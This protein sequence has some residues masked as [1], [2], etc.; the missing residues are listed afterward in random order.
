MKLFLSLATAAVFV[1]G[2][3]SAAE[4]T[5][6]IEGVQPGAGTLL[7]ALQTEDQFLAKEGEYTTTVPADS[8]TAMATF[9][10]VEPGTY[11]AAV[12]HDEDGDGDFTVGD[13]GPTEGWGLSGDVTGAP[14]FSGSMVEVMDGEPADATVILTYPM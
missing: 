5:V 1:T 13:N 12:V 4:V 10:D 7:V 11:A 3:A 8:E 6:S 9:D 14:E 2:A